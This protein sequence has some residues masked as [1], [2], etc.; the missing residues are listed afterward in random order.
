M[1]PAAIPIGI[2]L[3]A[4]SLGTGIAGAVSAGSRARGARRSAQSFFEQALAQQPTVSQI[5]LEQAV[6]LG[7]LVNLAQ[8]PVAQFQPTFVSP[9]QEQAQI[10]QII[11]DAT[12]TQEQTLSALDERSARRGLFRSGIGQQQSREAS[13]EIDRNLQNALANTRLGFTR[14]R[15]RQQA[16]AFGLNQAA[17]AQQA[18]LFS[19]IL[20]EAARRT[21]QRQNVFQSLLGPAQAALGGAGQAS[22]AAQQAF[23]NIGQSIGQAGQQA[24][25]LSLLGGGGGS[26]GSFGNNQGLLF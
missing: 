16:Q 5:P 11:A 6:G 4:A 21:G 15:A 25:L 12:K 17:Q 2:G 24:L 13:Q 8:R 10:D 7:G 22:A 18:Q 26:P 14:E 20:N 3:G 23:G 1:P 9:E 19:N